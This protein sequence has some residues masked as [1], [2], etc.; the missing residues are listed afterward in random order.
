MTA[1]VNM[2]LREV[3]RLKADTESMLATQLLTLRVEGT[4][5]KL[6]EQRLR[7]LIL[8]GNAPAFAYS[9]Y[10]IYL[11]SA[12]MYDEAQQFIRMAPDDES[13]VIS[14]DASWNYPSRVE[15]PA[16][17]ISI[18]KRQLLERPSHVSLLS[19]LVR[20][21]AFEGDFA[22]ANQYLQ[23]QL[24]LDRDGPYTLLSQVI[25][26]TLAGNSIEDGAKLEI[27][28]L[29]IPDYNFSYGVKRFMLGDIEG[30][31]ALWRE[32]NATQTRRLFYFIDNVEIFFPASVSTDP[33]YLA[34]LDD[35][36]VGK[37]WQRLL[38]E[39]I[40]SMSDIT[41]VKLN[42]KSQAAYDADLFMQRNNLWDHDSINYP[43]LEPPAVLELST[44]EFQ[45]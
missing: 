27:E 10:A 32:L 33:R 7:E 28:K 34:L 9:H 22:L 17:L 15:T 14:P 41:G 26:S 35:L 37:K 23:R 20:S 1:M 39:S 30:G 16:N 13:Y 3:I 19:S 25:I 6:I 18:K 12:R 43:G 8:A 38:M 40:V 21:A 31:I 42:A 45:H 2:A 5:Q 24:Q 36:G 29:G 11:T 4:N 44:Y